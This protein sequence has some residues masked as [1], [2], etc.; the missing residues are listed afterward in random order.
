M[1]TAGR[2]TGQ[3]GR[4]WSF[5]SDHLKALLPR[6]EGA[7]VRSGDPHRTS[8]HSR[9]GRRRQDAYPLMDFSTVHRRDAV[10]GASHTIRCSPPVYGA[11]PSP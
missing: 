2:S 8:C 1:K 3:A 10:A 5:G 6:A 7:K 4:M 9:R 11:G